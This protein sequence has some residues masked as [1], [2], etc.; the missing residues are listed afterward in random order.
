MS[1]AG[2]TDAIETETQT[3]IWI[4]H[5]GGDIDGDY[6]EKHD[7]DSERMRLDDSSDDVLVT[8]ERGTET[9]RTEKPGTAAEGGAELYCCTGHWDWKTYLYVN[10]QRA[11]L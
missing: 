10:V 9:T 8:R 11:R 5:T 2:D 4:D 6:F 7:D 3:K 1:G